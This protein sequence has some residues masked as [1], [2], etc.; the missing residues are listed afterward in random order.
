MRI[1]VCPLTAAIQTGYVVSRTRNHDGSVTNGSGVGTCCI[2]STD[3]IS[4]QCLWLVDPGLIAVNGYAGAGGAV[5]AL[6]PRAVSRVFDL[7][8]ATCFQEKGP[9]FF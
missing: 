7:K 4:D 6:T 2:A 5:A 9:V 8:A 3:T 1:K